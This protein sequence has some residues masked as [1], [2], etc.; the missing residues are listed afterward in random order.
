MR[1]GVLHEKHRVS[2]LGEKK[3]TQLIAMVVQF[4]NAFFMG[5]DQRIYKVLYKSIRNKITNVSL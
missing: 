5:W 4:F 2:E 3:M 1:L